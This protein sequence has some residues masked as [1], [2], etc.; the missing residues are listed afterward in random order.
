MV[1][2]IYMFGNH[3]FENAQSD[4]VK[5]FQEKKLTIFVVNDKTE[6]FKQRLDFLRL[7]STS[8]SLIAS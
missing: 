2:P 6:V 8:E 7:V 1:I 5:S 3:I 4:F